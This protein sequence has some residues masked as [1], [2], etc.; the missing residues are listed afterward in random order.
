MPVRVAATG[1]SRESIEILDRLTAEL[2]AD[3]QFC[4][5]RDRIVWLIEMIHESFPNERSSLPTL[6]FPGNRNDAGRPGGHYGAQPWGSRRILR[7]LQR[8]ATRCLRAL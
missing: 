2:A 4:D 5:K 1:A 7:D 3:C 8:F 6:P